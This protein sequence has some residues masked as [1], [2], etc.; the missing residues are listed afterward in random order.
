[1]SVLQ[2]FYQLI[3]TIYNINSIRH[4][5]MYL[6][7]MPCHCL[8]NRAFYFDCEVRK[9][10]KRTLHVREKKRVNIR[11]KEREKDN[12]RHQ[13]LIICFNAKEERKIET[14]ERT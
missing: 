8:N 10:R 14:K 9:R 5:C 13:A 6:S 7:V 11:K 1:M 12:A 2:S 4:E 3:L